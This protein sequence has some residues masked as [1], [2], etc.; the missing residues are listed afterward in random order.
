MVKQ[1]LATYQ[2]DC[3]D[4]MLRSTKE[5]KKTLIVKSPTGSGKT[6]MLMFF[7]KEYIDNFNDCAFVW[8]CPGNGNLEEQSQKNVEAKCPELNTKKLSNV[9]SEG[10]EAGD[11]AFINWELVTKKG[12]LS[13]QEGERK[14]LFEKIANAHRSGLN[15]IIII[16]EEQT[17]DTRKAQYVIDAF[18]AKKQ[19]RVSATAKE[20]PDCL[21]YEI[22]EEDV[23]NA[24]FITKAIFI[25][26]GLKKES[27]TTKN[28]TETLIDLALEKRNLIHGEYKKISRDINP[29]IVIQFPSS[30]DTLI[31]SVEKYLNEKGISYDNGLL[32]KWM[33]DEKDKINLGF[34]PD[35]DISDENAFPIV[36]LMKQAISE[37]WDCPR[38][39]ILVKLRDNMDE[40][41]EIQTIGRI[42]RMPERMHYDNETLDNCFL[43][44]L[45]SKYVESVRQST[46]TLFEIKKCKLKVDSS[47]FNLTKEFRNDDSGTFDEKKAYECLISYYENKYH[48]S[49]DIEENEK[50]LANNGYI[51]IDSIRKK[52]KQGKFDTLNQIKNGSDLNNIDIDFAVDTHKYGLELKNSVY[53]ICQHAGVDASAFSNLLKT[54]FRKDNPFNRRKHILKLSKKGFYAFVI[55][56]E[57]ILSEDVKEATNK[58][59]AQLKLNYKPVEGTFKVPESEFV[60]FDPFERSNDS[61]EKN[62][63]S[64]YNEQTLVKGIRSTSER[65]FERYCEVDPKVKKVYKNGDSGI[66]YFSIVYFD[67]FGKEW[68][69]YPDY[70]IQL[71][72]NEIWIIECKGGETSTGEN[73]NI[74][75][76]VANKFDALKDYAIS[77]NMNF[78]FVRDLNDKLYLNNSVYCDSLQETEKW[79][80]IKNF[81]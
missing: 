19:I 64:D 6:I 2:S 18:D 71:E 14:N 21:F 55:N 58:L 38:A 7:I 32:A 33:S 5:S 61:L 17:N 29:L 67:S 81:F 16:D 31:T 69:F 12:N 28:E 57:D 76:K 77:H 41:F 39:K 74:D 30:S 52:V 50:K 48:I 45:D 70:L 26:D 66:Q 11:I 53:H 22:S 15:F 20:R 43:Y 24:H 13:L 56:N 44:T 65:L 49:N 25:N 3:V 27:V 63:Y 35:W 46:T 72:N 4:Y 23:I 36:L 34:D 37:G 42:R 75:P 47:C 80:S 62:V 10:F 60:K 79:I 73:K 8:L 9:L 54:L 51:L 68:L 40:D 59:T 78:G 1:D